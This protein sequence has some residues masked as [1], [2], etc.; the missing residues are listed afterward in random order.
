MCVLTQADIRIHIASF[1]GAQKD[2]SLGISTI[3]STARN[4]LCCESFYKENSQLFVASAHKFTYY[5]FPSAAGLFA[6][7]LRAD[8]PA[9]YLLK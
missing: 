5:I 6:R 8:M 7:N 2:V 9:K 1:Q 4:V 3:I